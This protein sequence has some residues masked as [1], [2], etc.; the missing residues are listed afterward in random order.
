MQKLQ[1]K[2]INAFYSMDIHLHKIARKTQEKHKFVFN[3][4][5]FLTRKSLYLQNTI[6]ALLLT[7]KIYKK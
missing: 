4:F 3:N 2:Y 1:I 7:T 5:S 6:F